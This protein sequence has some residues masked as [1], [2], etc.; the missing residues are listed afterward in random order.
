MV[1]EGYLLSRKLLRLRGNKLAIDNKAPRDLSAVAWADTT[2]GRVL[3]VASDEAL[4]IGA[5]SHAAKMATRRN[6]ILTLR[7]KKGAD[8]FVLSDV[9]LLRNALPQVRFQP[10]EADD[11]ADEDEVDIEGLD[12][13]GTQLWLVGSHSSRRR[14]PKDEDASAKR[15]TPPKISRNRFLLARLTVDDGVILTGRSAD[16]T[17]RSAALLPMESSGGNPLT[18]VLAHD[19]YLGPF[20]ARAMVGD[21][22][23]SA[24]PL[25]G[26]DNGLDIEGLA[27]RDGRV[28]LGLRG[29]VL[30]GWAVLLVLSPDDSDQPGRLE[31]HPIAKG[32]PRVQ[33][34][35]LWLKGMGIRDLTFDGDDLL[36]LAGPTMDVDGTAAVWRLKHPEKLADASLTGKPSPHEE[37]HADKLHWLFNL[38]VADG[39]DRPE[40]FAR[41]DLWDQRAL[42]VVYDA[43]ADERQ[44]FND[45]GRA[46]SATVFADVFRLP[47]D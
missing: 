7:A 6:A 15:L 27:V 40:G 12:I 2:A 5:N 38:P 14:K 34:H 37:F 39:A 28:Y 17:P 4:G 33:K 1:A 25:P 32:G 8:T 42:M 23:D 9:T 21:D 47:E 13:V 24:V 3:W 43:A 41:Y 31:L 20:L 46:K 45:R 44:L 18:N 19:P 35:F 26:K 16:G 10:V 29:P 11:D 36:I 22:P 30:R